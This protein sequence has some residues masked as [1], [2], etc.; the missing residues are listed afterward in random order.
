M[1]KLFV[2]I[3]LILLAVWI[4]FLIDQDAGYVMLSYNGH[5][6]ETSLWVTVVAIIVLFCL[7]YFLIRL[8]KH[9]SS[10]GSSYKKWGNRRKADNARELTNQGLCDL[11][12]GNWQAAQNKLTK[13]AKNH[14]DPLINHLASARAAHTAKDYNKR[15]E[16]LRQAHR[17]KKSAAIAIG[18]TQATLQI[19]GQQWE[20]ALA[21][22]NHLKRIA[23]N[24]KHVLKLLCEVHLELHDWQ[25]LQN[26]LPSLKRTKIFS[27]VELESIDRQAHLG[28]LIDAAKT[29][30]LETLHNTWN[31]LPKKWRLDPAMLKQYSDNLITLNDP[32]LAADLIV[33]SLKKNWTPSL[34]TNY[35]LAITD[36]LHKQITVAE[37][38]LEQHPG[39]PE[40]LLCIGRLY[41]KSNLPGRAE[42]VLSNCVA[43]AELPEAY[44]ALA[45][46]F[47][48]L[49]KTEQ[50]MAMYKKALHPA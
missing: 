3:I 37:H 26:L 38:W 6:I 46:A 17:S 1:K 28:L 21:T 45:Q 24:H 43:T 8:F 39:E 12:E 2:A 30:N 9:T 10:I 22:L 23:P 50:A 4:G 18:L 13:A 29:Q 27:E 14:P 16:H 33:K 20:Q 5:I 15:D 41:L 7:F 31:A 19:D 32:Q 25:Q 36:D 42:D 44:S 11:A 35:G 40:L 47:E 34:V 49:G 48:A